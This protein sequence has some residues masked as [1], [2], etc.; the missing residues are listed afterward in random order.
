MP[1]LRSSPPDALCAPDGGYGWPLWRSTHGS[2]D[3]TEADQEDGLSASAR[4]GASLVG[5]SG[6]R[7]PV[8]RGRDVASRP[9]RA[10]ERQPE[11]SIPGLEVRPRTRTERDLELMAQ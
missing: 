2:R 6:G 3:S 11:E 10:I 7:S 9:G 5:A 4:R 1:S 8:R